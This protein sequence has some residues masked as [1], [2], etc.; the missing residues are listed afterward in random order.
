MNITN[1]DLFRGCL[2][3]SIS[4]A[5]MTNVY[6]DLS[7]EQSWDGFNYSMQNTEGLRG[8]ITF[9]RN[10][11]VGAIRNE[12]SGYSD[13]IGFV[14]KII[15]DFPLNIID[16][17]YKDTLQ[18]LL[19]EVNGVAIP[20]ITSIFWADGTG[21]H[22]HKENVFNLQEDLTLFNKILLPEEIAINEWEKYYEMDSKAISLLKY[23]Y[24]EKMKCFTGK[25][26]LNDKQKK[27]IPGGVINSECIES[28]YELNI[29]C[30]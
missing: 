16:K 13:N 2:I 15:S 21:I 1:S 24:N 20:C 23:L 11:C 18:Y 19:M 26:V 29:Y 27:L 8:T 7:Y 25:I 10:F 4:H 22:Y 9:D 5:I 17:A 30:K 3:A 6:P 28:L 12:I 14:K